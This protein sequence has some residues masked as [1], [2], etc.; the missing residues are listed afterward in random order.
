MRTSTNDGCNRKTVR[1]FVSSHEP[2]S[3]AVINVEGKIEREIT[4]LS[5][6]NAKLAEQVREEEGTTLE[7]DM[8]I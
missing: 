7:I 5:K 3:N 1:K 8:A 2:A 4:D 6:E